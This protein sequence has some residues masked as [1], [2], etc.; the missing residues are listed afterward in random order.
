MTWHTDGATLRGYQLGVLPPA[1]A[2]SVE[3]HLAACAPCRADLAGVADVTRLDRNWSAIT[4]RLEERSLTRV[5]RALVRLGIAE[6]DARLIAMTPS[7][8][9]P[10]VLGLVALV[11][12]VGVASALDGG[13]RDATFYAFVVLAPLLPVA[14]VAAAFGSVGDPAR[15]LTASTPKPAFEL[16][17]VRSL[18]VVAITTIITTVAALPF[19]GGWQA[20]AWLLPALGLTAAS[21]A[22]STWVAAHWAA[23]GLATAWMVAA[24]T[25][26]RANHFDPD[27]VARFAALRPGGQALFALVAVA[28]TAIFLARRDALDLRRSA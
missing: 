13:T 15:E 5:E 22:L 7:L 8:R 11:A 3:A 9:S 20:A 10:S 6:H 24:A 12:V 18:A 25:S 23:A 4:A 21:L 14:G 28:G 16:L 26:W 17:L 27:V 2:A 1:R 19:S